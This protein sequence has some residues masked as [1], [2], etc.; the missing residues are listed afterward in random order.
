MLYIDRCPEN[1]FNWFHLLMHYIWRRTIL[2]RLKLYM[3]RNY[4]WFATEGTMVLCFECW[5]RGIWLLFS[6]W[7]LF[8]LGLLLMHLYPSDHSFIPF[9][10]ISF[11]L[12]IYITR[13]SDLC[14]CYGNSDLF[15]NHVQLYLL[16]LWKQTTTMS[17]AQLSKGL[18]SSTISHVACIV[19]AR[20]LY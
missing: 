17:T 20:K 19:I 4:C 8:V 5:W 16:C 9:V 10:S 18:F 11:L 7:I 3:Y 6:Y 14:L 1:I 2:P 13:C 15:T 12:A